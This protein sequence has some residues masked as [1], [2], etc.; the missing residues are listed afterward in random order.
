M[1]GEETQ[2]VGSFHDEKKQLFIFPGTHSKHV[3]VN[4]GK[5]IDIKTYMTG[6]FFELLSAKSILAASVGRDTDI[7][8]EKNRKAFEAGLKE[9]LHSNLL[10]TAFMVRTN[11]L[12]HK[13]T[14]LENY[15]YLSGLLV[16]TE[17]KEIARSD[18]YITLVSNSD[19]SSH[20]EKAFNQ[21]GN[22][23]KSLK[24]QDADEAMVRGQL[25]IL[26][27]LL[28]EKRFSDAL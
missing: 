13:L 14:Q 25:K 21:I 5:V 11:Y 3:A 15:H 10:H 2:L 17:I 6:E 12:F 20:Y 19:L 16:G 7:T 1:R 23:S 26:T 9:S 8:N 18:H 22:K 27:R 4:N 24:M 28:K